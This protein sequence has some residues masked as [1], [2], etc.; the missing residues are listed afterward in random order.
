MTSRQ[1]WILFSL[2]LI[3]VLALSAC[4]RASGKPA[5]TEVSLDAAHN[6]AAQVVESQQ[7]GTA[8][9]QPSLTPTPSPTG[10]G[11]AIFTLEATHT[12]TP[13]P[14]S[15]GGGAGSDS[16]AVGCNNAVLV[17]T[18]PQDGVNKQPGDIFR[19]K[20]VIQNIGSCEWNSDFR[21][22]FIRGDILHDN[23]TNRLRRGI[24]KPGQTIEFFLDFTAPTAPGTYTSIW[25]LMTDTGT[26]FGPDFTSRIVVSGNRHISTATPALSQTPTITPTLVLPT[27]IPAS[28]TPTSTPSGT[29][30]PTLTPDSLTP[31]LTPSRTITPTVTM[32]DTG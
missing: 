22:V 1:V 8:T 12:L 13:P 15:S 5:P 19:K 20:W 23:T 32:M 29:P 10:T 28:P 25:R 17:S 31:T 24:I 14:P 3:G 9:V 26:L 18:K 21:F 7:T 11:T 4:N 2:L 30:T 27:E 6:S 16:G